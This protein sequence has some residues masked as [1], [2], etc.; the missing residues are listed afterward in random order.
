MSTNRFYITTAI[1]Y[2][3]GDPHLGTRSSSCR[4]TCSPGTDGCAATASGS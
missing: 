4:R 2:A 1:A 3:N